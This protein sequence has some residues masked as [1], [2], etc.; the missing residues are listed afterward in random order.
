MYH[1]NCF[2][3]DLSGYRNGFKHPN[4]MIDGSTPFDPEKAYKDSKLCEKY[5]DDKLRHAHRL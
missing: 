2:I 1:I 5:I 4:S 3:G